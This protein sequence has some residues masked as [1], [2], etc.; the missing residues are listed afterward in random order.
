MADDVILDDGI[1]E[2]K[3]IEIDMATYAQ[4]LEGMVRDQ[5]V[6]IVRLRAALDTV[7]SS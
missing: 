6:E 1:E 4:S 2:P 3:G 5:A 7:T